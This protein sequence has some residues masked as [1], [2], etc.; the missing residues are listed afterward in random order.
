MVLYHNGWSYRGTGI[1]VYRFSGHLLLSRI[2]YLTDLACAERIPFAPSGRI[3]RY[4]VYRIPDFP[5]FTEME[6]V[7][8]TLRLPDN[9]ISWRYLRFD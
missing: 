1:I 6:L 8:V 5:M 2:W 3:E 7:G 9:T 4:S